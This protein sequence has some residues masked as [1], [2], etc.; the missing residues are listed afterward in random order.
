MVHV[1]YPADEI[2]GFFI[3]ILSQTTKLFI[4][5]LLDNAKKDSCV[6]VHNGL[7]TEASFLLTTS[8]SGK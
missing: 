3:C 8:E 2:A 6:L 1:P 5:A 4:T 7:P